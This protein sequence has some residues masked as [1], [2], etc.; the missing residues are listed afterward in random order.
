MPHREYTQAHRLVGKPIIERVQ[1]RATADGTITGKIYNKNCPGPVQVAM[2]WLY[3]RTLRT[4]GTPN[5]VV[6]LRN[7][8]GAASESFNTI[9]AID[10]DG[11]TAADTI[12]HFTIDDDYHDIQAG[13]SL[14]VT[15]L[16]GGTT[17]TGTA[18]IDVYVMLVPI[19]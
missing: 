12:Q 14:D 5:H 11:G 15:L 10:V 7:G 17:T 3:E 6:T 19:D 16:V 4:G 9:G 8:D 1:L 2:A 13:E 18:L